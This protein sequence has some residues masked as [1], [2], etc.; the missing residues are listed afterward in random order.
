MMLLLIQSEW[1]ETTPDNIADY[2]LHNALMHQ[3]SKEEISLL[4]LYVLS[5]AFK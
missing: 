2:L 1:I 5:Q 3:L 4:N